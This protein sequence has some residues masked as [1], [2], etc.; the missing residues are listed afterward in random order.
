VTRAEQ[1]GDAGQRL[2]TDGGEGRDGGQAAA[3]LE[4]GGV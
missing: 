1:L 4:R 3:E 2:E